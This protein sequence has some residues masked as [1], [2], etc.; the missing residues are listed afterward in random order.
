MGQRCTVAAD[1]YSFGILLIELITQEQSKGRG[2]WRLPRAPE[3]CPQVRERA[4]GLHAVWALWHESQARTSMREPWRAATCAMH[5]S[6]QGLMHSSVSASA[7][8]AGGCG[9][10]R[11][12]HSIR[13][14]AAPHSGGGSAAAAGLRLIQAP[15]M[16][17]VAGHAA[18][19]IM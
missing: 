9:T 16:Y 13:P 7:W 4:G 15:S 12:V 17:N 10:H 3:E 18:P 19:Q 8:G 1:L 6:A 14:A 11:G 5:G 2:G